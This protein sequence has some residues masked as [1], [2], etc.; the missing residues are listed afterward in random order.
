MLQLRP[1]GFNDFTAISQVHAESWKH[2]YRGILSDDYLDNDVDADRL[3]YWIGKRDHPPAGQQV[4]VAEIDNTIIGFNCFYLDENKEFGSF[5][6]NLHVL[7]PYQKTG[8]GRQLMKTSALVM[9]QSAK[10]RKLYLWVFEAN[11]NA[12][13][14]YEKVGGTCYEIVD[15]GHEDGSVAKVCRYVWNDIA[16]LMG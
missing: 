6:D 11:Q 15:K 5:I 3:K 4:V 9:E 7:P 10:S 12:R 13:A 14:F 2:A 1:A 16:V 8:A